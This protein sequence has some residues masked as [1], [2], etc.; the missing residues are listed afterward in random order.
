MASAIFLLAL[1]GGCASESPVRI[2]AYS[3]HG[4]EFATEGVKTY[5]LQSS[6]VEP[7]GDAA[8]NTATALWLNDALVA[9]GLRQAPPNSADYLVKWAYATRPQ[10]VRLRAECT[11]APESVCD[12][13]APQKE[14]F[15]RKHYVHALTIQFVERSS[16]VLSYQVNATHADRDP[17]GGAALHALMS[18]AF[19]DFPMHNAERRE[20]AHCD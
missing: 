3:A 1:L 16:G 9:K 2:S 15:G 10:A 20:V 14:W 11:G 19:A 6:S 5:T 8:S 18:C 12:D 4:G 7:Q 17:A 13:V